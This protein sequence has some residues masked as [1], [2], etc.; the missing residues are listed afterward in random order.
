[1]E[2]KQTENLYKDAVIG[3]LYLLVVIV[4]LGLLAIIVSEIL[5]SVHHMK[6]SI[7]KDILVSILS[8]VG[9]S[10]FGWLISSSIHE[11]RKEAIKEVLEERER[12]DS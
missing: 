6:S 1:M 5:G 7:F 3:F 11:G 9:L 2:K 10:Y 8:V 12:S 4:V